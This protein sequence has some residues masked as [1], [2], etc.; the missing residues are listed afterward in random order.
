M[1]GAVVLAA[2]PGTR[3]GA[4]GARM[5][6]TMIPVAGRPFLEHLAGRLLGAGL[7]PVVVAVNHHADTIVRYFTGHPLSDGLRFVHTERRGTGADMAQCLPSL[8]APDFIVWN[9]DTIAD[10]NLTRF[11]ADAD[12]VDGRAVIALTRRPDVPNLGAWFVRDDGTVCAT[13]EARL[14]PPPPTGYAWRGSSTGI[15]HLNTDALQRRFGASLPPSLYADVLPALA[16]DRRLSAFDN[17]YRY[18]LD[19]GTPA[20][21]ARMDHAAVTGWTNRHGLPHLGRATSGP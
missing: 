9:G 8:D 2:G 15:V 3:L 21:L 19:F 12:S 10:I 11:C 17:G 13:L 1:T 6:K 18:F 16:E 14:R 5:P 20:D 4:L 7:R